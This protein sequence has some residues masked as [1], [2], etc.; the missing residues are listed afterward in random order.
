VLLFVVTIGLLATRAAD[1]TTTPNLTRSLAEALG[2][3]DAGA[4]Q[5]A[6]NDWLD[7]LEKP[8]AKL[9]ATERWQRLS[10]TPGY[11]H[12]LML[13]E[14]FR[15][16][17]RDSIA[18]IAA[19][20]EGREFLAQFLAD[21]EWLTMYLTNGPVPEN[22]A[23]GLSVLAEIW[24]AERQADAAKYRRLAT[25][26]A[27]VFN[28]EPMK[29]RLRDITSRDV[30]PLTP[31]AR[32]NFFKESQRAGKLRSSFDSLATWELRWLVGVPVENEALAW[33]QENVNV[34]LA[35]FDQ[36]CWVPRYRGVN[37]FG[38]SIQ[39]PLF[40]AA[41]RRNLNSAE[42]I[43][44]HGGVCGSLSYFGA[45]NAI[46]HGVPATPKGQPGH[47][48]YA[49]RVAPGEWMSCFGGPDGGA[50]FSIW[51]QSFSYTWLVDEAFVA[52]EKMRT[53]LQQAWLAR[54]FAGKGDALTARACYAQAVATQPLNWPIWH[55]YVAA[56]LADSTLR[57]EYYQS[58][59]ENLLKG[60]AKH[61]Q[62]L[63]DLLAEFEEKTLWP[64]LNAKQRAAYF[65]K[66]H[67]TIAANQRAGWTPWEMPQAVFARQA[68]SLGDEAQQNSF[69]GEV[70]G[71][72]VRHGH[73]YFIGRLI[74]WGT[75]NLAAKPGGADRFLTALYS[76]LAQGDDKIDDKLRQRLL[77]DSI[78]AAQTARSLKAFQLL[79]DAA[80]KYVGDIGNLKLEAPPSGKLVSGDGLLYLSGFDGWDNPAGH[81]DVLREQGGF[82]HCQPAAGDKNGHPWAIVQL[83]DTHTLTGLVIANRMSNQWRCKSLRVYASTDGV[84]WT[85][86]AETDNFGQQ[87]QAD[88]RDK[89]IKAKWLKVENV[90]PKSDAFHLRNICVYG[91]KA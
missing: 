44:R 55:E 50:H 62:P 65:L 31:L 1:P 70:L 32:Y 20:T 90:T 29:D 37:D 41:S 87:W 86:L 77:N 49:V 85:P 68:K 19:T 34:P 67:E 40:Y 47:C 12:G 17:G 48:A 80:K 56:C 69:F 66:I 74:D 6:V 26:T 89:K 39:G 24:S 79:S 7:R 53:S 81:R 59:A 25:A 21:K 63:C 8:L 43:A 28:T 64:A 42:D 51:Q 5:T 57:P 75:A 23:A 35:E 36:V 10:A 61:P 71:C 3:G 91:E 82:F 45:Y 84:N 18:K 38:D 15:V 72:Y 22:T 27:L 52:Q 14:L 4:Y 9:A 11:L 33:L 76:T 30:N 60:M 16:T 58:L 73:E 78:R 54:R 46:A 2:R 88:L 83:A 13:A